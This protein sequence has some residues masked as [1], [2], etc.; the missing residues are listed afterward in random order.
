MSG[1]V[2]TT[3]SDLLGRVEALV[4]ERNQARTEA[5]R[6]RG[7]LKDARFVIESEGLE[8]QWAGAYAAI[9]KALRGEEEA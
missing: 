3:A 5:E 8:K 6:L 7:A 1:P 9:Q 4:K 2:I